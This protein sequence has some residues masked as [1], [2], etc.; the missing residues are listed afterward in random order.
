MSSS[1]TIG[2]TTVGAGNLISGNDANGV[3]IDD[4][5]AILVQ[6]NLI[7]LDQTGTLA[8]GNAGAGVLIDTRSTSNTVG[9]L[10]AGGATY[11][12]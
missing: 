1:M 9:G 4:S 11:F 2:G 8:M 3:E 5:S 7:G 6:G 12:R 10:V